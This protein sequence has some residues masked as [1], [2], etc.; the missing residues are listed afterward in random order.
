ME[1]NKKFYLKLFWS[2][3]QIS[4]FTFGGGVV[5][6]SLMKKKFSEQFGWIDEEEILD[7]T[8]IAQSAPGPVAVNASILIGYR[9]AGLFGAFLT[10]FATI[11][12]PFIILSVLS[13]GYT[14]FRD[15]VAVGYAL[16]GMQAGVCAVIADVVL[17]MAS[18]VLKEKDFVSTSIMVLAFVAICIL[19]INLIYIVLSC[20]LVGLILFLVNRKEH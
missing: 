2:T 18:D 9:L 7:L 15:N 3:F 4:A 6:I 19:R 12:P 5:I 8:A 20:A 11:L 16:K 1:K 14:A 17:S 13:L 10:I